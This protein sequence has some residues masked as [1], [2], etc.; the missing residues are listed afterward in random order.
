[1][2]EAGGQIGINAL[3]AKSFLQARKDHERN[4]VVKKTPVGSSCMEH[5]VEGEHCY[6][7]T[8]R[9]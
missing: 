2:G 3:L 1:M 6:F 8:L 5:V 4:R 9:N 7:K